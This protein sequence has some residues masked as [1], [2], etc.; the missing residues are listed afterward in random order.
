[1][2]KIKLIVDTACDLTKDDAERLGIDLLPVTIIHNETIYQ[3]QYTMGKEQFWK[4]LADSKEQPTTSQITPQQLLASYNKAFDEGCTH[5]IVITINSKGSGMYNNAFISRDLFYEE[6]G[7][8]AMHIE[9]LDSHT[10]SYCYGMPVMWAA[11]NIQKG[12]SYAQVR[13]TLIDHLSRLQAYA[14]IFTLKF[15]RRSGRISGATAFVGEMLDFKPVMYVGHGEVTTNIKVRGMSNTLPKAIELVKQNAIDLHNQCI[16]IAYGD[17]DEKFK[18]TIHDRVLEEL[19]PASIYEG[20]IG[21]AIS[22]NAGP[23]IFGIFFLGEDNHLYD[24]IR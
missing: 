20:Q 16:G 9:I 3:E 7:Q 1:M 6:H 2:E 21:C 22:N 23:Q 8:D 11:Q 14:P 12:M 17:I 15:A 24:D 10:Y 18:Q 5:A 4:I 13:S 19:K